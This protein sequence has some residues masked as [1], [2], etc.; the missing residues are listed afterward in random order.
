MRAVKNIKK[1]VMFVFL[2]Y[3]IYFDYSPS[4]VIGKLSES[5]K[6]I[7]EEMQGGLNHRFTEPKKKNLTF[8]EKL[9]ESNNEKCLGLVL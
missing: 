9:K 5:I 4:K 6:Y 7:S 1:I 3:S 8:W 2:G